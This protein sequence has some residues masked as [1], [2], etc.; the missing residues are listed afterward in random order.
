MVLNKTNA[1]FFEEYFWFVLELG[2]LPSFAFGNAPGKRRGEL[3]R[4]ADSWSRSVSILFYGSN[5]FMKSMESKMFRFPC[6]PLI[7]I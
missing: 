1:A 5:S 4:N 3:G 2:G 6:L 7:A